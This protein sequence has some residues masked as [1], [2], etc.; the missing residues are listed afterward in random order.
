VTLNKT[1]EYTNLYPSTSQG[2]PGSSENQY[3]RQ[4][5]SQGAFFDLH[6]PSIKKQLTE[7]KEK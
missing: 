4:R 5:W 2:C 6:A 3:G 1:C 7:P